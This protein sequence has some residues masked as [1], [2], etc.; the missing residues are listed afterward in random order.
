[1][2]LFSSTISYSL[3][4]SGTLTLIRFYIFDLKVSTEANA[5][6]NIDIVY[7]KQRVNKARIPFVHN[8]CGTSLPLAFLL[9]PFF[10]IDFE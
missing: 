2:T 7:L 6:K 5:F 4:S 1:M 8:T 3:S 9:F 10:I